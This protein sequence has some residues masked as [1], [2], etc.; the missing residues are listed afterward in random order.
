MPK[1]HKCGP[2]TAKK[3]VTEHVDDKSLLSKLGEEKL[4]PYFFNLKMIDLKQGHKE[5]PDDV[6]LYQKQYDDLKTHEPDMD[7]FFKRC[8]D[9]NMNNILS[10]KYD[11]TSCFTDQTKNMTKT[12]TDIVNSLT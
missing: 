1:V 3:L 9:L 2:K 7:Q 5:H 10:K 4:A 8:D 11:W 12:L 6:K